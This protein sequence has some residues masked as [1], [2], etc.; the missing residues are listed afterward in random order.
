MLGAVRSGIARDN[1]A[2]GWQ[3]AKMAQ[4]YLP[5]PDA[6]GIRRWTVASALIEQDGAL[7]L[8]HN[9]RRGGYSDWSTPGGVVEPGEL[10]LAG[11]GREVIEESGITVHTWSEPVYSVEAFAP[12]MGWQMRVETFRALTWSGQ[13]AIDDPD[14][15][16]IDAEFVSS[17]ACAARLAG[18]AQWVR[19]P[20]GEWLSDGWAELRP[21]RYHV[22]GVDRAALTITRL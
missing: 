8:V 20:I 13:I 2:R 1:D 7:L 14:G 22:E 21:F 9:R 10:T 3:T 16:V 17:T 6:D 15:I 4:G 12:Q 19:E 11:L 18:A 5:Q